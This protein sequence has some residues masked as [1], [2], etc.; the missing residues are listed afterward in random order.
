[1]FKIWITNIKILKHV[2]KFISLEYLQTHWGIYSWGG[3]KLI[4]T[5][6]SNLDLAKNKALG[7]VA[8]TTTPLQPIED[9][10]AEVPAVN[11]E[12][13]QEIISKDL[14]EAPSFVH[15]NLK[16]SRQDEV[17]LLFS[18]LYDAAV[19][20]ILVMSLFMS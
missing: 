17:H 5:C 7:V 11:E 2:L 3:G 10:L 19:L 18:T 13:D 20:Y 9:L 6:V 15:K 14:K 8:E 4:A 16:S 1:M 12:D